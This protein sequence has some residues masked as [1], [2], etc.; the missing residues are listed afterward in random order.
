ME[1]LAAAGNETQNI[2]EEWANRVLDPRK[3]F[4]IRCLPPASSFMPQFPLIM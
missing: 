4:M 3:Y 1:K 2:V